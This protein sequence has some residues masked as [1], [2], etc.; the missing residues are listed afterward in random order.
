MSNKL[1]PHNL[2]Q[3]AQGDE[4]YVE[5]TMTMPG[6]WTTGPVKCSV[7]SDEKSKDAERYRFLRGILER[8]CRSEFSVHLDPEKM[9]H[10]L[11]LDWRF[12][13]E[14]QVAED[15]NQFDDAVDTAMW[16]QKDGK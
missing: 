9:F 7:V 16:L 14:I 15:S 8:L 3:P 11:G 4:E 13:S 6:S 10:S 2:D 5:F 1:Y 12:W